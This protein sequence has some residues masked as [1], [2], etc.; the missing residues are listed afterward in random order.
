MRIPDHIKLAVSVFAFVFAL[1]VIAR[2]LLKQR[3]D[4]K[5]HKKIMQRIEEDAK[6]DGS[7]DA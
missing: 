6:Q 4:R 1:A 3:D 5:M 7:E 2:E